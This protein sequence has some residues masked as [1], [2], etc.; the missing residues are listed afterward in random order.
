MSQQKAQPRP[1]EFCYM[2]MISSC[3]KYYQCEISSVFSRPQHQMPDPS[4]SNKLNHKR[5][6]LI[7][8]TIN[9][10]LRDLELPCCHHTLPPFI[11]LRMS[12]CVTRTISVASSQQS[13]CAQNCSII[14]VNVKDGHGPGWWLQQWARGRASRLVFIHTLAQDAVQDS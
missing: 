9:Q 6:Y 13:V 11:Q 14:R 10:F 5:C 4:L 8:Q 2:A 7:C 12:A 1:L 3:K